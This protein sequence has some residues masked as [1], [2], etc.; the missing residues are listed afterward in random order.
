VQTLVSGIYDPPAVQDRAERDVST[1]GALISPR[2]NDVYRCQLAARIEPESPNSLV[3]KAKESN[4]HA[5]KENGHWSIV[6]N[7]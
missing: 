7:H 1:V 2:L 5:D 3:H 6:S 4:A